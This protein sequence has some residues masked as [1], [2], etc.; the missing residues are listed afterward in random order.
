MAT[1]ITVSPANVD[2]FRVAADNLGDATQ[3]YRIAQL[4]GLRDP[5][6]TSTMTLT[7]PP[8]DPTATG[9]LPPQ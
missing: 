5:L 6:I 2:L 9:G 7:L 4:N 3:W 1:T 8:I